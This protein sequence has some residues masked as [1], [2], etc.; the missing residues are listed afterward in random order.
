MAVFFLHGTIFI[1]IFLFFIFLREI[2][3]SS[4]IVENPRQPQNASAF[5]KII[6]RVFIAF[7]CHAINR[8]TCF[9]YLSSIRIAF[10]HYTY[11]LW[12]Q[13]PHEKKEII[14][15]WNIA[16]FAI[17]Q[18]QTF[19]RVCVKKARVFDTYKTSPW[20]LPTPKIKHF[21][22]LYRREFQI[23]H[24]RTHEYIEWQAENSDESKQ[25][26]RTSAT[27]IP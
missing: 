23:K 8:Q 16:D 3:Y 9:N 6:H 25:H 21:H 2:I 20:I 7:N 12:Y 1:N 26:R 13:F 5:K 14:K 27:T 22:E 24:T 15:Q 19:H 18:N 10:V 11:D 4:L 17:D